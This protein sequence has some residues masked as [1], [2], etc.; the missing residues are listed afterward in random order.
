M[1]EANTLIPSDKIAWR[2]D[3]VHTLFLSYSNLFL[4]NQFTCRVLFLHMNTQSHNRS[5]EDSSGRG[6]GPSQRTR[7]HTAVKVSDLTKRAVI[8]QSVQR[9]A[10]GWM[11]RETF[12]SPHLLRPALGPSNI[13]HNLYFVSFLGVKWRGKA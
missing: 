5:R 10:T 12:F 6:S 1:E 7:R 13:L 8:A 11:S 4:P 9:V 3:L 2:Y